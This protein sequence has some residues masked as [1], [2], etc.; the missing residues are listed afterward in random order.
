MGRDKAVDTQTECQQWL[1]FGHK[2]IL[3]ASTAAVIPHDDTKGKEVIW[4]FVDGVGTIYTAS[5]IPPAQK[6]QD[7]NE[8]ETPMKQ[9]KAL[10]PHEI[11]V[12][13]IDRKAIL[14]LTW[15][16][17]SEISY[18]KFRFPTISTARRY[19]LIGYLMRNNAKLS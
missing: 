17:L 18:E 14:E 13:K 19:A 2:C 9:R 1:I 8:R 6:R 11:R 7:P 4:R 15:E 3:P 12:I 10:Q 5:I 16:I